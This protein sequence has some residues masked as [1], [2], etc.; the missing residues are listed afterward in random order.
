MNRLI[1]QLKH[2][3]LITLIL[4]SNKDIPMMA[5]ITEE[6]SILMDAVW[7]PDNGDGTYTNPILYADYSDSR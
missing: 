7:V 6:D 3:A 4:V 2:V 5:Q 1:P